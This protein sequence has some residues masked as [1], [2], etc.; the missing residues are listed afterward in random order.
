MIEITQT[1]LLAIMP[2]AGKMA[3]IYLP[4]I[5]KYMKEFGIAS[6]KLR[7]AHFLAQ[8]AHES[9]ELKYSKELSS[10]AQYDTGTLAK[11]LGN[12]PAKDGDGQKYKGRGLIQLTGRANYVAYK[13]F[14]GYDVVSHPELLEEPLGA[15]R[16]ACWYWKEHN[17][18][19]LADKDDIK[20][21]TKKING[22]YNGLTQRTAYL[23]KAK[24]VLKV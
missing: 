11:R 15:T 14:C 19:V 24:K 4:F 7:I 20:S 1:Q 23:A 13:R 3:G 8:I 21:I 6:N 12:T 16:V 18:N 17:L 10:G 22:G 5:N 9:C 2:H